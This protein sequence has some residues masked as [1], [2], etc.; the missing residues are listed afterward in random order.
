MRVVVDASVMITANRVGPAAE[1]ARS[2]ISNNAL[3]AP[4]SLGVEV[5]QGFRRLVSSGECSEAVARRAIWNVNRLHIDRLPFETFATRV[6][7]LRHNVTAH[8]AWYVAI[9][10]RFG[11]PL[12]TTDRRLANA[13]GPTC[14]FVVL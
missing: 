9:A 14:E 11:V 13:T 4:H 8:D 1:Q 3:L 2:E 6:W 10:E 5:V 7:E 12:V